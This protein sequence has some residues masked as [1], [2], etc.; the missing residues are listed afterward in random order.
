M[1]EVKA[2][3]KGQR[4]I[5]ILSIVELFSVLKQEKPFQKLLCNVLLGLIAT[6]SVALL[7]HK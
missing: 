2:C 5:D 6:S 4:M 1:T 7:C 3:K